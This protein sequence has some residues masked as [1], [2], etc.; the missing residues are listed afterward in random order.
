MIPTGERFSLRSAGRVS[1]SIFLPSKEPH[2]PSRLRAR[3]ALR[4]MS[5]G[6][7]PLVEDIEALHPNVTRNGAVGPRQ[8][9]STAAHDRPKRWRLSS[10]ALALGRLDTSSCQRVKYAS[11]GAI[12]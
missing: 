3:P 4:V 5:N 1:S 6:G 11:F 9:A 8:A 12:F 7:R 10:H 2:S